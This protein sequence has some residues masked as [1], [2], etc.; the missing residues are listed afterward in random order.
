[1]YLFFIPIIYGFERCMNLQKRILSK[2]GFSNQLKGL[3]NDWNVVSN[4]N[5]RLGN[6]WECLTGQDQM[7]W[8]TKEIYQRNQL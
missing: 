8:Y 7:R 5:E 2:L 6:Y 3:D 1:M 4:I